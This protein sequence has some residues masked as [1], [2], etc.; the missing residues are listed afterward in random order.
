M[1][2]TS[3]Q[4]QQAA[5]QAAAFL[6]TLAHT[7]RLMILCH[8]LNGEH[9]V[10]AL[11]EKSCLSQSAFSQHLAK[12]RHEGLVTTRKEAQTV[13]YALAGTHSQRILAALQTI[14]CHE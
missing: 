9:C 5:P 1:D 12:L 6:K 10:R 7:E 2:I 11:R 3:Q 14:Y 4:I 13:Y 8:L